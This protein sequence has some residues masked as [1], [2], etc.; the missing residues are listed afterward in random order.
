[1]LDNGQQDDVVGFFAKVVFP[2][3]EMSPQLPTIWLDYT[4]DEKAPRLSNM[5]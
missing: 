3:A 4:P 2:E 1:M 5:K